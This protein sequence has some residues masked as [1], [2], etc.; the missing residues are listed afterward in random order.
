MLVE[1]AVWR[2]VKKIL[3]NHTDLQREESKES[4]VRRVREILLD[5]NSQENHPRD[6]A[7][8]MG[9]IYWKVVHLCLT[10]D[11]GVPRD[12]NEQLAAVFERDVVEQ[13]RRC[14]I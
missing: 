3:K 8:R 5:N 10:G 12:A 4:D 7:F 13:L 1:I 9:D 2:S 6:I 11:F 14:V